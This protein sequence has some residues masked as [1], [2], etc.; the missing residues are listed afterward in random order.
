MTTATPEVPLGR[1]E[2]FTDD[3]AAIPSFLIE[4]VAAARRLNRKWFWLGP[5]ILF[6]VVSIIASSIMMPMARHVAE[7]L[8]APDGVDP[9]KFQQ[10]MQIGL[11]IQQF[12]IYF[13]PIT[14]AA[15]YAL[16]ALI[17]WATGAGLALRTNFRQMFNLIAGCSV[18]QMLAALAGVVIVKFKG[19]PSN[20]AGFRPAMGLDLFLPEDTNKFVAAAIGYF[21]VFEIWWIVMLVL[22]ISA[23]FRVSKGKAFAVVVPLVILSIC[24]RVLGAFGQR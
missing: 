18:I 10:Q 11:K 22:I 21:S 19:E 15:L 6:S 13:A 3:L 24:F 23:G 20:M 7:N 5:L 16:Q 8:P 4:P 17:L 2:S 14:V 9:D 12:A 1:S